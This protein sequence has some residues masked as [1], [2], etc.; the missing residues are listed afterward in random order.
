[1]ENIV[2]VQIPVNLRRDHAHT[3]KLTTAKQKQLLEFLAENFNIARAAA[4]VGVTR[5]SIERLIRDN[6]LFAQAYQD[7]KDLHLDNCEEAMFVVASQPS[8][9]GF[10]DRKL[11]LQAHRSQIYAPRQDINLTGHVTVDLA[12]VEIRRLLAI[13]TAEFEEVT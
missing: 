12:P 11:A 2:Q 8:R 1:M 7:V 13:E 5:R 4:S 6:P 3:K 9:D 10:N